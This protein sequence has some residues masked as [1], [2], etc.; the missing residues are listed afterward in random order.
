[1][2][3]GVE[4]SASLGKLACG[5]RAFERAEGCAICRYGD[6]LVAS[7]RIELDGGVRADLDKFA[8]EAFR[9]D[10]QA[11]GNPAMDGQLTIGIGAA[12]QWTVCFLNAC[13]G[14][15]GAGFINDGQGDGHR[16]L[17]AEGRDRKQS[18][19]RESGAMN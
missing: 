15:D 8:R 5:H 12:E 17:R 11:A 18:G 2:R 7:G 6:L 19:E 13:A 1:M 16:L 10:V 3:D 9:F 4:R 14:D